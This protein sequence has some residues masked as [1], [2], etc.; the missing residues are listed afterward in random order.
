MLQRYQKLLLHRIFFLVRWEKRSSL[1][2]HSIQWFSSVSEV[3]GHTNA[4]DSPLLSGGGCP[5]SQS[6]VVGIFSPC[7]IVAH[8]GVGPGGEG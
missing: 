4:G 3:L 2:S 1:L 5:Y 7:M 8:K 6:L